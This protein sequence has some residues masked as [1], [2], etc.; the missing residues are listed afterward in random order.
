[1]LAVLLGAVVSFGIAA[2]A[3]S[4]IIR[5]FR[6]HGAQIAAALSFDER[7]FRGGDFRPTAAPRQARL[8]PV[9]VR[10]QSMRRAA[11]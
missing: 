2:L 3:M 7:A 8:V 4:I 10:T 5:E 6:G 9:R 11:A 1:M